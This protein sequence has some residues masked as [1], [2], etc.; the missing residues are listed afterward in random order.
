MIQM[1]IKLLHPN[2]AKENPNKF[3]V[4]AVFGN[5][6][7]GELQFR[8]IAS[9]G[10]AYLEYSPWVTVTVDPPLEEYIRSVRVSNEYIHDFSDLSNA[11]TID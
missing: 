4:A 2:E 5:F 11:N 6:I 7:W 9:A 10:G 1:Q 3:L 8:T